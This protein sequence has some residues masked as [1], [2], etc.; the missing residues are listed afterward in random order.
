MDYQVKPLGKTCAGTGEPLAPGTV[1]VSALVQGDDGGWERLDFSPEGWN[2]PPDRTVGHWSCRVPE[3]ETP[4]R[5]MLDPEEMMRYFEQLC[6]EANPAREPLRFVLALLLVRKRRLEIESD[7]T[8]DDNERTL[9]LNGL[10]GE[11][12]FEVRDPG[13]TPEEAQ[14]LQTELSALL[15]TESA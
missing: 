15:I 10:H 2:G 12:R 6:E 14:R 4:G 1:V 13:L 7:G 9:C 5:R 8:D 11:G 3:P